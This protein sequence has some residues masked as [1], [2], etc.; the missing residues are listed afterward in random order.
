M[1]EERMNEKQA[2]YESALD[3]LRSDMANWKVEMAQRENR[4]LLATIVIV[5][6]AAALLGL[7][8]TAQ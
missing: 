8:I 7:L 4:Q 3:R 2:E 1:L 6:V 5:G